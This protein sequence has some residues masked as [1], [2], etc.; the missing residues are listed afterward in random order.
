[1]IFLVLASLIFQQVGSVTATWSWT[2]ATGG[3]DEY[4]VQ[5]SL[6]AGV[7]WSTLKYVPHMVDSE[8]SHADLVDV[9]GVY[10]VRVRGTN[11]AH[12]YFGPWSEPS[13]PFR[14][15]GKPGVAKS[16]AVIITN[17]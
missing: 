7:T 15:Y 2:N 3:P 8:E 10:Q 17:P 12:T 13:E 11:I 4:E 9:F 16:I 5:L 1:M 14:T 6:D